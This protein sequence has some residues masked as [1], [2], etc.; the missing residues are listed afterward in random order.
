M[1]REEVFKGLAKRGDTYVK[2]ADDAYIRVMT[3]NVLFSDATKPCELDYLG[4]TDI[5]AGMCA[6][7]LPDVIGFQEMALYLK[8]EFVEKFSDIYSFVESPTGE[9]DCGDF[10]GL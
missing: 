9:R 5:M 10:C 2:K 8:E 4:R 7:Y 1:T 6:Y 3:C